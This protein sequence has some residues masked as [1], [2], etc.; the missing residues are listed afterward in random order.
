MI[1]LIYLDQPGVF[2]LWKS[3]EMQTVTLMNKRLVQRGVAILDAPVAHG[4]DQRVD[5]KGMA[6]M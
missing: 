2:I 5:G 4:N 3:I 1:T 6:V